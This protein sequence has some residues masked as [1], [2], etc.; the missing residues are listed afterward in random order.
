MCK[1]GIDHETPF[2]LKILGMLPDQYS[3]LSGDEEAAAWT[4]HNQGIVIQA[5]RSGIPLA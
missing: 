1:L 4:C 3:E 5:N 2:L